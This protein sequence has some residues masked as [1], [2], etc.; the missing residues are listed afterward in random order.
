MHFSIPPDCTTTNSD[1]LEVIKFT[2]V[3]LNSSGISMHIQLSFLNHIL[4]Y[5]AEANYFP[6]PFTE[7]CRRTK[8][9]RS[10][11]TEITPICCQSP[12]GC[13]SQNFRNLL[14]L[15]NLPKFLR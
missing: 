15:N 7:Q 13:I 5:I 2:T 9:T 6:H 14:N 3:K 1:I 12:E 8:T 11:L 10:F 4:N